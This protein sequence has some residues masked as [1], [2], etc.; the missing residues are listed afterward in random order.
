M[1]INSGALK[2][3]CCKRLRWVISKRYLHADR[4]I[5]I[6]VEPSNGANQRMTKEEMERLSDK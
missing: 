1:I 4:L 5:L 3:L 6:G 2:T